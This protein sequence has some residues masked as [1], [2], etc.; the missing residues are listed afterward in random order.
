MI[1]IEPIFRESFIIDTYSSIKGRGIH[2][3]LKRV[4]KAVRHEEY[5][6]CL[7][8]D[9]HKCYPSLDKEIL[10]QKLRQKFKDKK[11]MHLLCLIIDSCE[12]GVPIGNYTS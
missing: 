12:K 4:K 5:K 11:L 3:C 10:K 6:Y 9:I 7:K 8:L 1:Y 2:K